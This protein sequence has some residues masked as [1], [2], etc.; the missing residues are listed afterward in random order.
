[1][2]KVGF[3]DYYK[4]KTEGYM[5]V[6]KIRET[7]DK[8]KFVA[9]IAN[10]KFC[11]EGGCW[12]CNSPFSEISQSICEKSNPALCEKLFGIYAYIKNET[13]CG[14]TKTGFLTDHGYRYHDGW[15]LCVK[16]S[17]TPGV[18]NAKTKTRNYL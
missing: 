4:V 3:W 17:D 7:C 11:F 15:A 6:S 9:V 8:K 1:M 16:R 14:M 5:T 13:S 10:G 12:N 18:R 2:A